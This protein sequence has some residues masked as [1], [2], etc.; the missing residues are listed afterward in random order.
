V[1]DTIFS[2][3]GAG[4]K[5]FMVGD[6]KQSIYS[7]R[8]AEPSIFAAYRK[9]FPTVSST[10]DAALSKD[11][12]CVF[13]SN[14]FRCDSPVIHFTNLV[15]GYAF[16]GCPDTLG[17]EPEDDL[18]CS[19]KPPRE[20]YTPT[21]VKVVLLETPPRDE[22]V[23]DPDPQT[24][25]NPEAVWVADEIARLLRE[26]KNAENKPLR[27]G[28]VAILMRSLTSAGE[29]VKALHAHGIQT[30]YAAR[31]NLASHPDIHFNISHCPVVPLCS[32]LNSKYSL[33]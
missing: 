27:A 8:S 32:V 14:N 10:E 29:V 2:I 22:H 25:L 5:R 13:M 20:D 26:E 11:G 3:I 15:C 4:G 21:P 28:D 1:Q 18:I 12:N 23:D 16:R 30:S 24:A 19:K 17:Y 6:I 9:R 31:D 33:D 7:F